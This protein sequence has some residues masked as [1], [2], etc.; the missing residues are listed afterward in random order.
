[1][2]FRSSNDVASYAS[3]AAGVTVNLLTNV[4]TGGDAQGDKLYNI[5][6]VVGSDSV[7]KITGNNVDNL[8][9]GNG[10][11]DLLYGRN[12]GDTIYGGEDNDK[13]YGENDNDTLYGEN[14]NDTLYGGT[15]NDDLY[16][17]DGTD[18]FY[19]GAGADNI[20]GGTGTSDIAYYNTSTL[21]V[22][23][24]LATNVNS[25]GEAEGDKLYSIE[26]LQ[27]SNAADTITGDG[28]VNTL[29]GNGGNDSI[30]G[31]MGADLLFG[32]SGSD[33]FVF[34]LGDTGQAPSTYDQIKDYAK[35]AV[36]IGDEI[37][38]ATDLSI[39]GSQAAATATQASIDAALYGPRQSSL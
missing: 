24:N 2:L 16:G 30:A 37:D 9:V 21:G 27:G 5:N 18:V 6:G 38:F 36:G 33:S 11:D 28:A 31:G 8:I 1:M 35:G 13:L 26:R 34:N 23:V 17:G 22:T 10:G 12:G 19:G 3:S 7:D 29:Y 20:Y 32:G 4:H 39:G 15:G 25:G 14:G